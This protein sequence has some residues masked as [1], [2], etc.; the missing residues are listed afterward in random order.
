MPP[1]T[2]R[3]RVASWNAWLV[4]GLARAGSLLG[5]E[6]MLAEAAATADFLLAKL[7]DEQGRLAH[8]YDDG[9]TSA[10]GFLEDAAALLEAL[11]DLY[12][13]GAGDRFLAAAAEQAGDLVTRFFDEGENDLFLTPAD[14]EPRAGE[15]SHDVRFVSIPD[16]EQMD[17]F[18]THRPIIEAFLSGPERVVVA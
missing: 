13:A 1:G 17:L 7:R 11:L 6:S 5:D 18:P 4:S 12:R 14:G 8:V 15:E 3:K 2:D 10:P 9:R 16:V